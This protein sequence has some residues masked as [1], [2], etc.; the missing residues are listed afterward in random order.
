MTKSLFYLYINETTKYL[1]RFHLQPNISK[2]EQ[3]GRV[4]DIVALSTEYK[5]GDKRNIF[6]ATIKKK[7]FLNRIM[8]QYILIIFDN[9][10]Q[11]RHCEQYR[12]IV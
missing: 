7:F 4:R 2:V 12:Q 11:N 8:F 6:S 9:Q 1:V 3:N 10:I 5:Q